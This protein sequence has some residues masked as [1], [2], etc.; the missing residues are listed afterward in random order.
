MIKRLFN[1]KT[2]MSDGT[3]VYSYLIGRKYLIH[4][5]D[6]P[7]IEYPNGNKE[8]WYEDKKLDCTSQKEFE[9]YLKLKIFW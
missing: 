3:I 5:N 4:R 6:G 7:A 8:W 1:K 2:T 9:Q